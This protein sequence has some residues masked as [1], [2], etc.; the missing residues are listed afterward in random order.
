MNVLLSIKPKYVESIMNGDKQYEFRKI[1]FRNRDIERVFI[2][3]TAPVKKIIGSFLIGD[4]I[5]DHP[6]TLWEQF[7]DYSGLTDDKF[8]AYFKGSDKGFAIEIKRLDKFSNIID[9]KDIFPN[10]VPPQSFCYVDIPLVPRRNK[11]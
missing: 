2:Y 1:I 7:K 3:S 11:K 8:F 9:P 4:I 10:F 6:N 5:E